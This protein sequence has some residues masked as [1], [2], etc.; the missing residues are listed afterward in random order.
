MRRFL[1]VGLLVAPWC[2]FSQ[3]I[4]TDSAR[5]WQRDLLD[6]SGEGASVVVNP[7]LDLQVGSGTSGRVYENNRGARFEAVIDGEWRVRGALQER[8]GAADPRI[9]YWAHE[10]ANFEHGTV[11][12]P[13]WGRAKW[14]DRTD[15]VLGSPLRFDASRATTTLERDGKRLAFRTGLDNVHEGSGVGSA[16]WSRDAAPLPFASLSHASSTWH[17]NGWVGT[18]IGS[19]RG[20]VGATAEALYARQRV[21][22]LGGGLHRE[23]HWS[24]DVLWYRMARV[25]FG[26]EVHQVRH[27]GGMQGSVRKGAFQGYVGLALDWA[28]CFQPS[29]SPKWMGELVHISWNRPQS[30]AWIEWHR[31][32]AG[33]A[34][35][36]QLDGS[37]H[38]PLFHSATPIA[39]FWG[40]GMATLSMG[41]TGQSR[42][43]LPN[44]VGN[45]HVERTFNQSDGVNM[46][47]QN[48]WSTPPMLSLVMSCERR[49]IPHWPIAFVAGFQYI[50]WDM[51][52]QGAN[53]ILRNRTGFIALSHKFHGLR[54]P[55]KWHL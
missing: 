38:L 13:G 33:S 21:S 43:F 32:R 27:W 8:Q 46:D 20:P 39:H 51:I 7:L 41:W 53:R 23:R 55:E 4:A 30:N 1:V 50:R 19:E 5:W 17:A 40:D 2:A 29:A 36:V 16:F 37:E 12:I 31:A 28:A 52:P 10:T 25:P 44:W 42:T 11:A 9:S 15:Y 35:A 22:R 18:A 6:F 34:R 24:T 26:S 45:F 54:D 14:L 47:E 49:L 48:T 3:S